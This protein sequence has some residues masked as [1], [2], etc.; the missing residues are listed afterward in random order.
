M[1]FVF[2]KRIENLYYYFKN[3]VIITNLNH[4][5]ELSLAVVKISY[6]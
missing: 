1:G 4:E 3:R 6:V 2:L 5:S